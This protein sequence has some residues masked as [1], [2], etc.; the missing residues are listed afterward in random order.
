M[1]R[2]KEVEILQIEIERSGLEVS[3]LKAEAVVR[4]N[5][6][7]LLVSA[8]KGLETD[9]ADLGVKFA[10]ERAL[11]RKLQTDLEVRVW[12]WGWGLGV[13]S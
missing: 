2:Q 1:D 11:R 4:G 3:A 9:K 10:S 13:G 12:G 7:A 8:K 6:V 5:E